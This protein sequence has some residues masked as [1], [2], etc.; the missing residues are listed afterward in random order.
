MRPILAVLLV[1]ACGTVCIADG[2]P[3]PYDALY[4]VIMVR[5]QADDQ[6]DADPVSP[7]LWTNSEYLVSDGTLPKLLQS[8]AEFNALSRDQIE[9]YPAL[10]RAILQH[11]LWTVFDWTTQPGLSTGDDP[12]VLPS[13]LRKMQSALAVALG[14]L[15]LSDA[16]IQRLPNP[17][18]AT[19][20]TGKFS[21]NYNADESK[22][23][24]LPNDIL[25]D[26]GPWVCLSKVDH[27][28]PAI[29][30]TE[31]VAARSAFHILIRLPEGRAAALKYVAELATLRTPWSPGKQAPY[32]E[33]RE[34]P[35]MRELDYHDNPLT[36]QFPIGTQ[37]ALVEQAL[38]INDSGNLTLSP[39]VHR[40]QL[41]AYLNVD[42]DRRR[43]GPAI[44][45]SQ[46][47]SEFVMLPR[48]MMRGNVPM[49]PIAAEEIHHTTIF[50][51]DDPIENPP[52]GAKVWHPRL[53]S[54]TT[55]H[56][57]A[58][59]HSVTSR[60]ELF[61]RRRLV[62]PRYSSAAAEQIGAATIKMKRG[63]YSWGLLQGLLAE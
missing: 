56:S 55:C 50:R 12:R 8:L 43:N 26:G 52:P 41:R 54:C 59:I 17:L 44:G 29:V 24:F 22:Q 58:G 28:V 4:D 63:M 36:P 45:P 19:A 32:T 18:T 48:E 9:S 53:N 27:S 37:F 21:T 5:T 51:S 39:L 14:K 2:R 10:N 35:A 31:S 30:H 61:Q 6:A 25:E 13:K 7:L 57:G 49:R 34:H 60:F 11:H 38:L 42:I 16:E 47:V 20:A 40:V 1:A 23:P 46:A 15:A 62:P 33:I 3:D